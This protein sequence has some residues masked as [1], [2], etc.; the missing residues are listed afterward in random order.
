MYPILTWPPG[1]RIGGGLVKGCVYVC[2][3]V[4]L[5][6]RR[7][8]NKECDLSCFFFSRKYFKNRGTQSGN[9]EI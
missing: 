7:A 5:A 2:V 1:E 8:C 3:C 4:E 9:T 6:E